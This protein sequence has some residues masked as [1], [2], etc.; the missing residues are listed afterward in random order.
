M[1]FLFPNLALVIHIVFVFHSFR[2]VWCESEV[3]LSW[4]FWTFQTC[5]ILCVALVV[6]MNNAIFDFTP[7]LVFYSSVKLL[8][9]QLYL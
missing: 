9:N 7:G 6:Y 3:T 2:V 8:V 4:F 5:S 1:A